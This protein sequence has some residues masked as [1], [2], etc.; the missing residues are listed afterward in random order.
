MRI[1]ER[2]M[3]FPKR[4]LAL[5]LLVLLLS[6]VC[7]YLWYV[8]HRSL[9]PQH[10]EVTYLSTITDWEFQDYS[11]YFRKLAEDKGA[12]YAFEVLKEAPIQP[13][14]DL[15]LLA[16]IVG[17]ILYKQ[18]GIAAI[19][20]C[21]TDFRN[22]CSHAVV[23]GIL[24]E[25]GEG[26]LSDIAAIC[27]RAPGG[28]GAYTMCFHGLGHGILAFNSYD[29]KK[30]IAMC[31][32]TGTLEYHSREY[33]ECVGGATMEMYAG[34][35]D[36]LVWEKEFSNYFSSE[37]PLSP[38]NQ[39]YVPD[40]VRPVCYVYISPHLL[41]L[42]GMDLQH[43]DPSYFSKAFSYCDLIP[44]D[45]TPNR[46]ACYGGIGKEFPLIASQKDSR[47]VGALPED[48]VADIRSWCMMAGNRDGIYACNQDVLSSLFWGGEAKPDAAFRYCAL[49][50]GEAQY[51]C[52]QQLARSIAY[53]KN[54]S[55]ESIKLCA[56]L[57]LVHQP[58]CARH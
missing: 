27:K 7:A 37:D 12:L 31:E 47:D 54:G 43:P 48:V 28:P 2:V 17:D 50:E 57:P 45:G 24:N 32:K 33:I 20:L 35:H 36:P 41:R 3:T 15:H 52:Y 1:V 34:V 25:H 49:L 55:Y 14:V 26:A 4:Y 58:I 51:L 23:I 56:R 22:A 29:Y 11:D 16:H 46:S 53:F 18:K 21:T 44:D 8:Y 9:T 38:C 30:A 6:G 42:A 39:A 10:P 5:F 13:G 19:A 40:L